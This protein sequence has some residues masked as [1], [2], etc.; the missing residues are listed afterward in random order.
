VAVHARPAQREIIPRMDIRALIGVIAESSPNPTLSENQ[1]PFSTFVVQ[2]HDD[3]TI[4]EPL[5]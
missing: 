4:I 3:P 2:Q 1:Y 5:N